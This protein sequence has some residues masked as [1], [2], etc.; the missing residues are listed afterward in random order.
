MAHRSQDL[1]FP[2]SDLMAC[3]KFMRNAEQFIVLHPEQQFMQ[4]FH[5]VLQQVIAVVP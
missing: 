4:A 1:L 3:N 2:G 5:L